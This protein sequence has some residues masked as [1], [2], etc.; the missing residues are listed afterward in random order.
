LLR[1]L[2]FDY[3]LP[4][5]SWRQIRQVVL[6]AGVVGALAAITTGETAEHIVRPDRQIVEMHAFFATTSTWIY[7]LL[8]AGE[9]LFIL[10][11]FI[12]KKFPEGIVPQLF[13]LIERILTN[14]ALTLILAILGVIAISL[15]GLLG[16][17]MVYGTSAD[18]LAPH[19]LKLL[20]I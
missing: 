14:R 7:G 5:V 17:I 13:R 9:A 10:N 16:G 3:W 15:T 12:I 6:L 8:L 20:G 4:K 19:V 2:P 1:I 11:P 18:P